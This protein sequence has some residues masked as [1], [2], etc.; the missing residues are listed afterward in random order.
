[1]VC[2]IYNIIYVYHFHSLWVCYYVYCMSYTSGIDPD[3]NDQT[4]FLSWQVSIH[5][6]HK[7]QLQL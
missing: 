4:A 1:M 3:Q 2:D 5:V 7:F 6:Y